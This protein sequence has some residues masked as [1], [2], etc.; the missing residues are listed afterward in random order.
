MNCKK[1]KKQISQG[2]GF[3]ATPAR[4]RRQSGAGTHHSID[5]TSMLD[6]CLFVMKRQATSVPK[7][8][9][10]HGLAI[11]NYVNAQKKTVEVSKDEEELFF[12]LHGIKTLIAQSDPIDNHIVIPRV[13]T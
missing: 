9:Q 2:C 6:L 7:F 12:V 5:V 1:I 13:R 8:L 3:Y 4:A 11:R 10:Q